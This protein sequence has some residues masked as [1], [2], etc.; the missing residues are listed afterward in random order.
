MLKKHTKKITIKKSQ[1]FQ[2]SACNNDH[3]YTTHA[4]YA[5]IVYTD[6]HYAPERE[7]KI[8]RESSHR[9]CN[10][11]SKESMAHKLST[12]K[13]VIASF[14]LESLDFIFVGFL[15]VALSFNIFYVFDSIRNINIQ[16]TIT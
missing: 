12:I 11:R 16:S 4:C 7:K 14:D 6:I 15:L 5:Y 10:N 3:M 1:T 8:G 13:I 9:K 2:I